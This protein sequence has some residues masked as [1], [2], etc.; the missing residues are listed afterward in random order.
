M[1]KATAF[2]LACLL[3]ALLVAGSACSLPLNLNPAAATTTAAKSTTPPL[4][5]VMPTL[6]PTTSKPPA[7]ATASLDT[8]TLMELNPDQIAELRWYEANNGGVLYSMQGIPSAI[9]YD[10]LNN[11]YALCYDGANVWVTSMQYSTLNN[12]NAHGWWN[13]PSGGISSTDPQPVAAC[14]DGLYI[15]VACRGSNS[16]EMIMPRRNSL[17]SSIEV[18]WALKLV[19]TAE[20]PAAGKGLSAICYDGQNV[21][22][23][24]DSNNTLVKM[25]QWMLQNGVL[26]P[27]S[28]PTY[29]YSTAEVNGPQGICFDSKDLWVTNSMGNSVSRIDPATGACTGTFNVGKSPKGICFDGTYLWVVNKGSNTVTKLSR[30]GF[31]IGT[32][33]V[34]AGPQEICFD[35]HYIWVTSPASDR[36]TKLKADDGSQLG[37][38]EAFGPAGICFDGVNIWV[39]E[40]KTSMVRKL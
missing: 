38:F 4:T 13:T 39:A 26:P 34:A 1:K 27:T 14:Y 37:S 40:T 21:W 33:P 28:I 3:A 16:V 17:E 10:V 9:K 32:Y 5:A 23:T 24:N 15:W 22:V 18:N 35:G 19:T 11:P 2:L 31:T 12:F 6:V 8:G 29:K 36:V 25:N 20:R 7:L 30:I